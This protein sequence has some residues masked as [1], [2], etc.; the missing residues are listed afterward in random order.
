MA[1]DTLLLDLDGTVWDSRAWYAAAIARLCAG[2]AAEIAVELEAGVNVARIARERGVTNARLAREAREHGSSVDLYEGVF[3]TLERLR[4]R[5]TSIGVVSNLPGWLVRPLLESTGVGAYVGATATPR[6]GV[7]AKPHPQGVKRVLKELGRSTTG[8]W[9]V[10]DGTAD[11]GAAVAAGV[12]FAWASYG[13]DT[14]APPETTRVVA[15]FED[16]LEL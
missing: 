16:V 5:P 3:G 13:Y 12:P 9:F 14:E 1:A 7:P 15:R 4:A 6:V 2:T 11:A 8:A 10:G